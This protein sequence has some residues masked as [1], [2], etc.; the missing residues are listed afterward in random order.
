VNGDGY[1]DVIV[2]AE[3]HAVGGVPV[4][5]AFVCLGGPSGPSTAASWESSGDRQSGASYG[6]SVASA[7][8]VNGDGYDDI[9]IGAQDFDAGRE[10]AGKAY[11][12]HGGPGGLSL[13]PAWESSGD[14]QAWA[15]FGGAAVSAGDV[16][17]DGYDDVIVGAGQFDTPSRN[18]G[19]AYLYLG[20]PSGLSLSPAWEGSGDDRAQASFGGAVA[21]AGDTDGDGHDDVI[22]GAHGFE[23]AHRMAGKAYVYRGGPGGLFSVPAWE[24]SGDDREGAEFGSAVASAGDVNGDGYDDVTVGAVGFSTAGAVLGRAYLYLGGPAG[25]L[26]TSAWE[27]SGDHQEG[28][29]FGSSLASAGDVDGDGYDDVIV[30]A[31]YFDTAN[32]NAGR[33]YVHLG[34]PAGLTVMSVWESSGDDRA[35]AGFGYRVASAGDVDRDGLGDVIVGVYEFHTAQPRAGKAYVYTDCP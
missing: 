5:K 23:T 19:K 26:V 14:D 33:V 11:V 25:P 18:A 28:A 35:G 17:G 24:H 16:N 31:R 6:S 9:I 20:G 15:S 4:G 7:G 10:D 29:A 27:S 3:R 8:D 22:V 32:P 34:G 13:T 30:G 12:Y 21:S 1:D 2:G